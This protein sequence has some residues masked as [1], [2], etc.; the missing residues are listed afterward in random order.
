MVPLLATAVLLVVGLSVQA[1]EDRQGE[2]DP[3]LFSTF[4]GGGGTDWPHS[5]V[6]AS[7]GTIYVAGYTLS[8]DFPTTEGA[9]QR[10]TKGNE[11]VCVLCL[12]SDGSELLWSTLIGGSGQDI[13]WGIALGRDGKVYVTGETWSSDFPTTAGA[14][15]RTRDGGS[16][17]F[18]TCLAADGGS[19]VWSTLL[20]GEGNDEG[21]ALEV[22]YNGKVVVAGSTGSF[23]FPTTTWA[24]DRSLGGTED[25]FVSRLSSDG[26][27]LEASTFLGGS[28][29]ES[30]PSLT[31]DSFDTIWL[32]GSTTSQDFPTTAP[33]PNDW[34]VARDVFVS[35]L[36]SDLKALSSSTV[37]GQS[38]S[39]VPRSIDIGPD[40]Q[41]LVAGY[42]H[43]PEFPD[44]GPEPG[45]DNTG[46]WDGF[47]LVYKS[48]LASREHQWLYGGDNYDV[49]RVA[50]YDRKGMIH[51][52]G[53][54]NSTNFPTTQGSYRPYKSGDDHDMFYMQLDPASGYAVINST[55]I[56]QSMGDFGMGLA[57]DA[58][59][60][61]VIAG[62][63]RSPN[64][65]T[66]GDPYDDTHNGAG[67]IAVLKYT[68]DE[69][70]PVFSNDTTPRRVEVGTNVTFSVDV[71]DGTGVLE[72][73]LYY[74]EDRH[75]HWEPFSVQMEGRYGTYS[76]TVMVPSKT[77]GLDYRFFAWD[78]LGNFLETELT[79]ITLIDTFPPEFRSD[80]SMEGGTTGDPFEFRIKTHDN[81]LVQTASVEYAIGEREVNTSMMGGD[82]DHG[83][84]E[85][86]ETI[87][88]SA[89]SV[90]PIRYRFHL[91]DSSGNSITT[92]W[93]QV[94]VRDNDPPTV[95]ELDLPEEAYS[96]TWMTVEVPVSDNIGVATGSLEYFVEVGDADVVPLEGPFGPVVR[97]EIPVPEGR[98][99]LHII[100]RIS[101]AAGNTANA[102][103]FVPFRDIEP[104][105]MTVT[106]E[107]TTS[108]GAL[109][110]VTWTARDP[111][112]IQTMLV[113]YV[114][115]PG[116][117]LD[118][119]LHFPG[120]GMPTAR[121]EI[122][123]PVDRVDPLYLVLSAKD[124]HGNENRTEPLVIQ[125][126]DDDPPV[127]EMVPED[128]DP[129]EDYMTAVIDAS[130]SWD[131][132]GIVR[133]E[134][135]WSVLHDPVVHNTDLSLPRESITFKEPGWYEVHLT[136]HDSAGNTN[137][138]SVIHHAFRVTPEDEGWP[139][140]ATYLLIAVV[141][142]A[143]VI[144][145]ALL[146]RRR[147]DPAG[148]GKVE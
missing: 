34:N 61:P 94:P 82:N 113:Y 59:G 2:P 67:D 86:N 139:S 84:R 24:Y 105:E 135:S 83:F 30:E 140:W 85:F 74:V 126:V 11:D 31:I 117:E 58:W 99:E 8:Y 79:T 42:T 35:A 93:N 119:Y 75:D 6:V 12:S 110:S 52:V 5:T 125:V 57:F 103:A 4:V 138:S 27:T 143:A 44:T 17:G 32:A 101:D 129:R 45:N 51:L 76:T 122:P 107:N 90:D 14:Y 133:Y 25:V 56:G 128:W 66:A 38:G 29:S 23:F 98:G 148:P 106:Y 73:W 92:P 130:R 36:T 9:Y 10:V 111:A 109:Y 136:V 55:Y 49:V 69:T 41:V 89:G 54:T 102:T 1:S 71:T 137:T 60:V 120:V 39:D 21:F 68:T 121:A 127:V 146:S 104:P 33:L 43:S 91:Q 131:N 97:V 50:R 141:I 77:L 64:F 3:F 18:V 40:G 100:V 65:P 118:E 115:G 48:N 28:Y 114:F 88:L 87:D 134:W 123:I 116:H 142:A 19:L 53:Y 20:G 16:D 13:A 22:L 37:V 108:T 80:E 78:V 147:S 70:P 124:V 144:L 15:Q 95:G 62:H 26:R 132:I 81:W 7:N 112:G 145:V 96:G 47:V 72:V 63:T 46:Y